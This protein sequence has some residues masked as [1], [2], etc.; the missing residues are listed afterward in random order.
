M[1]EK[2][3]N[4][5]CIVCLCMVA[6]CIT[7]HRV[8]ASSNVQITSVE[9]A[10]KATGTEI[11]KDATYEELNVNF[12]IKFNDVNEYAKYKIV[13][14]NT[15]SMDYEVD[16]NVSALNESD[17]FHYTL[18]YDGNTNVVKPNEELV[19]YLTILYK[20]EV[21][22]EKFSSGTFQ[23]D[24]TMSLSLKTNVANPNTTTTKIVLVAGIAIVALIVCTIMFKKKTLLVL[25]GIIAILPLTIYALEQ[26]TITVN[27]HI[28]VAG[29]AYF[30]DRDYNVATNEITYDVL[31]KYQRGMTWGDFYNSEYISDWSSYSSAV[32]SENE[33]NLTEK[34]VINISQNST[35]IIKSK[36]NGCYY[37]IIPDG[38]DET[39]EAE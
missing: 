37:R 34:E 13:V 16:N 9:L 12:S 23:E 21:P 38:G 35:E 2:I 8:F 36:N 32:F 26:I 31:I 1:K 39:E 4:I 29:E 22:D 28:E 10:E 27:S 14:K 11:L 5:L 3:R 25:V 30:C 15:S 17:Y 19:M 24:N 6:I 18:T 33:E 7:T 20:N